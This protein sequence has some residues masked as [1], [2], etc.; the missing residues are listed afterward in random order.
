[1]MNTTSPSG[2]GGDRQSGCQHAARTQWHRLR[3]MA[4]DE[5]A[6]PRDRHPAPAIQSSTVI[7][8]SSSKV[9]A[10]L[11]HDPLERC[12]R[13]PR[14]RRSTPRCSRTAPS[15]SSP[16]RRLGLAVEQLADA[17]AWFTSSPRLSIRWT[18]ISDVLQV[19]QLLASC[20]SRWTGL[21]H[22]PGGSGPGP[23]SAGRTR[24]GMSP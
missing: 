13:R 10:V 4:N 22:R 6:D 16:P 11:E 17:R 14:T 24:S 9:S 2:G 20:R 21:G 1:M 7:R 12:R 3:I 5:T 15:T 18:S 23:R 8:A 19:G